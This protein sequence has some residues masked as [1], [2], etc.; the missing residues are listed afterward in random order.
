MKGKSLSRVQLLATPWTAAHQATPPWDFPGKSTGVGCHCLLLES[1][2]V[3]DLIWGLICISLMTSD[4]GLIFRCLFVIFVSCRSLV[5]SFVSFNLGVL[6]LL[7]SEFIILSTY[8]LAE[9]ALRI[10]SVM[11]DLPCFL[12]SL[13]KSRVLDFNIQ[14]ITFCVFSLYFL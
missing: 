13:S 12:N 3:M 11:C 1:F 5:Q 14:L 9:S 2:Y 6:L 4:I 7:S 8:S 10:F